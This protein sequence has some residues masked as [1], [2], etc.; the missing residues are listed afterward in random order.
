MAWTSHGHQIIGTTA[1]DPVSNDRPR[2]A[3]CGGAGLC[4]QC[5]QEAAQAQ[6]AA[7]QDEFGNAPIPDTSIPL[8]GPDDP[9]D[10]MLGRIRFALIVARRPA[11]EVEWISDRMAT[12]IAEHRVLLEAKK[13]GKS[14]G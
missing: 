6:K 7:G 10:R 14:P 8:L 12:I 5:S 11:S 13:D 3:R 9:D 2:I 1:L 4:A